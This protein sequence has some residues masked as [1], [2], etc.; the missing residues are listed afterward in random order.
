MFQPLKFDCN[1]NSKFLYSTINLG[2]W[3]DWSEWQK[4]VGTEIKWAVQRLDREKS[5][6][7]MGIIPANSFKNMVDLQTFKAK[8]KY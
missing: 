1:Y 4:L 2:I 6:T 5:P 7:Y 3:N 8:I